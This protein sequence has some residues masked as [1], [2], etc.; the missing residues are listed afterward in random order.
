MILARSPYYVVSQPLLT[1]QPFININLK[2]WRGDKTNDEPTANTARFTIQKPLDSVN[3]LSKNI[4]PYIRDFFNEGINIF[5]PGTQTQDSQVWVKTIIESFGGI[6]EKINIDYAVEGYST[7]ID[8]SNYSKQGILQNYKIDKSIKKVLDSG[9]TIVALNYD[10]EVIV[11]TFNKQNQQITSNNL[12]VFK[13]SSTQV[14]YLV[15]D[16]DLYDSEI[17]VLVLGTN[18]NAVI[19]RFYYDVVCENKFEPHNIVFKNKYG[20]FENIYF[21]KNAT[22]SLKIENEEYQANMINTDGSYDS[23]KHQ[24]KYYNTNTKKSLK[25]TSGFVDEAMNENFKQLMN[26]T[27]VFLQTDNRLIPLNVKTTSKEFKQ[28]QVDQ[29]ISYDFEFEFAFNEINTM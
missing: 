16:N 13:Q 11:K 2:I 3:K 7:Y 25:L 28:E 18:Q 24:F 26:S 15:L 22:E 27:V 19:D 9:I 1:N 12:Q 8:G 10:Q 4:A 17:E 20:A 14:K 6:P 23:T 21:F 5:Q 29:K